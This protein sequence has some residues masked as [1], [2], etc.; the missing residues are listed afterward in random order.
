MDRDVFDWCRGDG[1]CWSF[2]KFDVVIVE[3]MDI[4]FLAT[5]LLFLSA[6]PQTIKL[7]RTKKSSDISKLTYSMTIGGVGLLFIKSLLIQEPV[8][9]LTNGVSLLMMSINLFLI[10]RY[11]G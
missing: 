2:G 7:L 10:V 4:F 11:D 1:W 5:P 8:L 3:V 9:I 6:L